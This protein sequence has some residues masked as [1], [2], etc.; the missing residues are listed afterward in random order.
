M[1]WERSRPLVGWVLAAGMLAGSGCGYQ[2]SV[3]GPGPKI[4]SGGTVVSGPP[5]RMA[6]HTFANRS[7][8]PNLEF[9]YTKYVR[10]ALQSAG[11]AEFTEDK[12]AADFILEGAILSV[13]LPSLAFSRT[14]TQESRV[15]VM[16]AVTV[17]DQPNK[18]VRWSHT[19]T[20]TAEFYVGATDASGS[21]G[22]LQFNRILQDR[23][24]EQAGQL[25]AEDIADRL[26]TAREQGK[27]DR[28]PKPDPKPSAPVKKMSTDEDP[29]HS[30]EAPASS[31]PPVLNTPFSP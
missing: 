2:F 29:S 14:Q 11:I 27:F 21:E 31:G 18:R 8:E 17:R 25:V 12:E 3:D 16:V 20:S 9:K 5:L 24:V 4:G 28:V 30:Q 7:F 26:L 23:A 1:L 19:G 15:K 13:T 10:Q 22:G 6:I